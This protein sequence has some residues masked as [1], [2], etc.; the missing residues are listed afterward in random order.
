MW[1]DNTGK[2]K[3]AATFDELDGDEVILAL[4]D[5][6][7]KRIRLDHLSDADQQYIRDR[8][9][10]ENADKTT[11]IEEFLRL[12]KQQELSRVSQ[13]EGFKAGLGMGG[14]TLPEPKKA[15]L[16]EEAEKAMAEIMPW[17]AVKKD[18]IAVYD[19]AFSEDELRAMIA[20]CRDPRFSAYV[21]KQISLIGPAMQVGQQYGA[22]LMPRLMEA[23]QRVMQE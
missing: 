10:I 4:A 2:F 21:D 13:L 23:A 3:R 7:R 15:R 22:T 20:M 19:K 11:L 12:T 18:L 9:A 16:I 5:D 17:H 1:T 8:I 6:S 14:G